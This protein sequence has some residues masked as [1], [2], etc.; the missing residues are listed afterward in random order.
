MAWPE[1]ALVANPLGILRK[2][3]FS[4]CALGCILTSTGSKQVGG[5]DT[6]MFRMHPTSSRTT[7]AFWASLLSLVACR[8]EAL[9]LPGAGD[10]GGV[11][12]APSD[13]AGGAPGLGVASGG[14]GATDARPG[15]SSGGNIGG[16][17]GNIGGAGGNI[18]GQPGDQRLLLISPEEVGRRL[19]LFLGTPEVQK[20]V[21]RAADAGQFKTVGDVFA[22]VRASVAAQVPAAR[23]DLFVAWWLGLDALAGMKK[24]DA[25]FASVAPVLAAETKAFYGDLAWKQGGTLTTLYTSTR[26]FVMNDAHARL[27]GLPAG[28][29]ITQATAVQL[30]PTERAGLITQPS[31]LS[32]GSLPDRNSI[33][34]RGVFVRERLLCQVVPL[35]PP[36]HSRALPN[37]PT[38]R[39]R[40]ARALDLPPC[41]GCHNLFDPIGVAFERYD[42][43]G[44]YRTTEGGRPVDPSGQLLD[45]P[46]L[47]SGERSFADAL[48]LAKA[49]GETYEASV[50]FARKWLEFSLG[51]ALQKSDRPSVEQAHERFSAGGRLLSLMP[52]A[53]AATD[54]FLAP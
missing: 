47:P 50:C 33:S 52:A 37:A 46:S 7:L 31:L 30:P 21:Q 35:E 4:Y 24:A 32:L 27:Y 29:P 41:Q 19:A 28:A 15:G 45:L 39:E 20:T 12:G 17:G 44:R 3:A 38:L 8:Q 34:L 18:G 16:A 14:M 53:V 42:L 22:L 9:K 6:K 5:S 43:V 49:M 48:G 23:T 11:G 36:G 13:G 1:G 26:T 25:A 40:M 10:G 54:A 2:T 51:R